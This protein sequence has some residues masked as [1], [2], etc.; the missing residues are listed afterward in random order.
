MSDAF[1]IKPPPKLRG[2]Q[3]SIG[4]TLASIDPTGPLRR[5]VDVLD[6][7]TWTSTQ[8]SQVLSDNGI[9]VKPI[10]VARHR[11]RGTGTGCSCP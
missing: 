5:L 4:V 7:E 11:R 1:E 9:K 10:T 3:C 6:D 2:P 8:I